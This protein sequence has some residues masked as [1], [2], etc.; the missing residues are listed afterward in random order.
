MAAAGDPYSGLVLNHRLDWKTAATLKAIQECLA[1][2]F[3]YD[4]SHY[5]LDLE[6]SGLIT[7]HMD[8][9]WNRRF[10]GA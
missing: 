7:K 10:S 9:A 6:P 8:M 2:C 3:A 1:F 4:M 5:G